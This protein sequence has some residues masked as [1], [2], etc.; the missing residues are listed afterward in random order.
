MCSN[1]LVHNGGVLG[2]QTFRTRTFR[3][4]NELIIFLNIM[5]YYNKYYENNKQ[6]FGFI[7]MCYCIII[8]II[9]NTFLT[10][11]F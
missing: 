7:I 10:F 8:P 1:T 9:S 11:F 5:I 4:L 2:N 6:N 3:N